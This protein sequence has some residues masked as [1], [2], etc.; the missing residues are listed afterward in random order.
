MSFLINPFIYAGAPAFTNTYSMQM[1]RT[2]TV[3]NIERLY[4]NNQSNAIDTALRDTTPNIS[5]S[6]WVKPSDFGTRREIFCK[7]EDY[8]GRDRCFNI[9]FLPTNALN[10]YAQ[11]DGNNSSVN[12]I[13]SQIFNSATWTHFTFVYDNTQTTAASI[14]KLYIN[15]VENTSWTTQ[16]I[17]TT[18]KRFVNQT[19][20]TSRA[21]VTVGC[22]YTGAVPNAKFDG[23]GGLIDDLTF[24]DK[25]LS[26]TEVG[27]LYNSGLPKD[28]SQMTSYSSN[29]LAWY[30]MGDSTGDVFSTNWTIV[31]VKGTANTNMI[32]DKMLS[33]D[34]V[35]DVY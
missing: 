15:G 31:N 34:R 16:T 18:N 4:I 22:R 23:Y 17:N 25:S 30:R 2:T 9:Y 5:V 13:T 35:T 3:E 21:M 20:Q 14:A 24:W 26:S 32:S 19:T 8:A 33:T 12:L 27:E 6:F 7:S 1:I 10:I 29:C 11:Y 28:V